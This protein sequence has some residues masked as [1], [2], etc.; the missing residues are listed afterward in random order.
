MAELENFQDLLNVKNPVMIDSKAQ[1]AID[2]VLPSFEEGVDQALANRLDYANTLEALNNADRKWRITRRRIW[3]DIELTMS[4]DRQEDGFSF[5]R[6]EDD[7]SWYAGLQLGS[8]YQVQD[9]RLAIRQASSQKA[10]AQLDVESMK[11]SIGRQVRE[12]FRA[13]RR[14]RAQHS[15]TRRNTELASKRLEL[16]RSLYDL[17]RG[18]NFSVTDAE[19]A[20]VDAEISAFAAQAEAKLSGYRVMHALGVLVE[21]PDRLKPKHAPGAAPW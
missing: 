19:N 4:Y 21:A 5:D 17:G 8:G 12:A 6:G 2:V 20:M 18:D 13:Y 3:P 10:L 15:I 16:A 14:A 1:P 11:F 9:E 7:G